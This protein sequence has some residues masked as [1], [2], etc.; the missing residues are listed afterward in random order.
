MACW[1]LVYIVKEIL[2]YASHFHF[3]LFDFI[4]S[5]VC[6]SFSS[7][8]C[9]FVIKTPLDAVKAPKKRN[10]HHGNALQMQQESG[11]KSAIA[12]STPW[13]HLANATEAQ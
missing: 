6:M 2:L 1:C 7:L 3:I 10:K 5:K 8:F 9:A 12:Q 11:K 13:Q 4:K